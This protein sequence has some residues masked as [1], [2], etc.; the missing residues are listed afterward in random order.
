M[1]QRC[2]RA[3]SQA[4]RVVLIRHS[5]V[6][7]LERYMFTSSELRNLGLRGVDVHCV[8]VSRGTL[9]PDRS[10]RTPNRCVWQHLRRVEQYRPHLIYVHLGKNDLRHMC[11][12]Q[13][14]SELL[15]F[16]DA[17]SVISSMGIVIV[18]QLI[19]FPDSPFCASVINIYDQLLH[20]VRSPQKFWIHRSCFMQASRQ[21]FRDRDVHALQ[22]WSHRTEKF[23]LLSDIARRI[24][25]IPAWS[26][27]YLH[28]ATTCIQKLLRHLQL[29]WKVCT[30]VFANVC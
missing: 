30:R 22:W 15:R 5:Y 4:Q 3:Q 26:A 12:E 1:Q 21:L 28:S 14:C 7:H 9:S 19:P 20:D 13:I 11:C 27:E 10:R 24:Y 29:L 18:A 23:P 6:W 17:L 25:C 8:G 16:V 2:R